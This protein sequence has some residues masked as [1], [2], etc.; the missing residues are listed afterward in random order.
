MS[1]LVPSET[2]LCPSFDGDITAKRGFDLSG[3]DDL[4]AKYP[5]EGLLR[6]LDYYAGLSATP[7][8]AADDAYFRDYVG[9]LEGK[10]RHEWENT[11]DPELS[12]IIAGL[13]AYTGHKA[14]VLSEGA[15]AKFLGF[16][17]RLRMRLAALAEQ[18]RKVARLH[19]FRLG[20]EV[21]R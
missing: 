7:S 3:C 6:S 18:K 12:A 20:S 19:S 15:E 11:D 14:G 10:L 13:E 8:S 9:E 17:T 5:V 1:K 21:G 16:V 2:V 4:A